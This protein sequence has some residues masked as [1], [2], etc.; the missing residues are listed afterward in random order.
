MK[1]ICHKIHR[2]GLLLAVSETIRVLFF[3]QYKDPINVD[4]D[5]QRWFTMGYSDWITCSCWTVRTRCGRW[6]RTW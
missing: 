2:I 1:N 5:S 4:L 6:R 3:L